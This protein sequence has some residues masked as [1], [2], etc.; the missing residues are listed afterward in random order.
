MPDTTK[1]G[2]MDAEDLRLHGY[3]DIESLDPS[4]IGLGALNCRMFRGVDSGF[5]RAIHT[6]VYLMANTTE[7]LLLGHI[8]ALRSFKGT[9]FLV[10]PNSLRNSAPGRFL[11]S[12]FSPNLRVYDDMMWSRIS[13]LLS[14]YLEMVSDQVDTLKGDHYVSPSLEG[15]NGGV[16][17]VDFLVNFCSGERKDHHNV[18]VIKANPGVGKTALATMVAFELSK[19]WERAKVVPVF[20]PAD[21]WR[22]M[23]PA[24]L[25]DVLRQMQF[26]LCDD[27]DAFSRLLQQGYIA[28]IFDGFDELHDDNQTPRERFEWLRNISASS[29]ARIIVTVRSS[30]WEREIV[31]S[32]AQSDLN[33][34][35]IAPFSRDDRNL[36]W[37]SRLK[38]DVQV[39]Q[40]TR[41]LGQY[42]KSSGDENIELFQLPNCASM[43]ADC[44]ESA[45]K[46]GS[47]ADDAG[48]STET[49]AIDGDLVDRFFREVMERERIRQGLETSTGDVRAALEEISVN[50]QDDEQFDEDDLQLAGLAEQDLPKLRDYAFLT[51]E[52][53]G[54]FRFRYAVVPERFRAARFLSELVA[55]ELNER[56]PNHLNSLVCHE[57]DGASELPSGVAKIMA[58]DELSSLTS[59]HASTEDPDLKSLLFHILAARTSFTMQGASKAERWGHLVRLLGGTRKE[60]SRICVKGTVDGFTIGDFTFRHSRFIDFTLNTRPAKL[61]FESCSFEGSLLLPGECRYDK[62]SAKGRAKL[63]VDLGGYSAKLDKDD[64][65]DYL[66]LCLRRFVDR[67]GGYKGV[68][69]DEWKTGDVGRI[70]STLGVLEEL[71]RGNVVQKDPAGG[72]T[73]LSLT[74]EGRRWVGRFLSQGSLQGGLREVFA[75]MQRKVLTGRRRTN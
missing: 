67:S 57:A 19:K 34:F 61:R 27:E 6:F 63:I 69:E 55:G 10:I 65:Q 66:R 38:D 47:T 74:D 18:I 51:H 35:R 41:M 44:V 39:Q 60:V 33:S 40:A 13:A 62:C 16:D 12:E 42:I 72:R 17:P 53:T 30:F 59:V 32:E 52:Q 64:L 54:K 37:R 36:Y 14:P 9:T 3:T 46:E 43:I 75:A 8:A 50:Y 11:Q 23:G 28:L 21:I 56:T 5:E 45:Q 22:S 2:P 7:Q 70:E 58:D 29:N 20:L 15:L 71:I 4:Q 31:G 24:N 48:L 49:E 73:K 68:R 26:P 1:S 25:V